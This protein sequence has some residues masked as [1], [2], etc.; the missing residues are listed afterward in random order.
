MREGGCFWLT[1][2]TWANARSATLNLALA[3]SY[4]ATLRKI[5]GICCVGVVG[6]VVGI[7]IR[8]AA[9]PDDGLTGLKLSLGTCGGPEDP[10]SIFLSEMRSLP[11]QPS[12]LTPLR[13]LGVHVLTSISD[14]RNFSCL[15]GSQ[16]QMG[17]A[18][19]LLHVCCAL[20]CVPSDAGQAYRSLGG[21]RT[22]SKTGTSTTRTGSRWR[23]SVEFAAKLGS[24]LKREYSPALLCL[25]I[26]TNPLV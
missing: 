22:C 19:P 2:A 17:T 26:G 11:H 13:Y 10:S 6:R 1:L 9:T 8:L 12:R 14:S 21:R 24:T 23:R 20:Y 4:T 3:S 16:A 18:P 15:A 7:W 5:L 25:H